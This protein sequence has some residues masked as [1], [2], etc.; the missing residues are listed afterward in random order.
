MAVSSVGVIG[1]GQMGNGIAH[2]MALAGYDV[3][4]ND[5]S[6]E[7]LEK[8]IAQIQKNLDRQ[9][10]REKISAAERDAALAKIKPVQALAD[11]GQCDLVI[12]AATEKEAVKHAI[13]A[14]L[15]PH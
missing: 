5:I 9:V 10:S 11:L 3:L 7:A 8:A 14:E 6:A 2:V 4:L 13:F 12:E 15:L 1:A